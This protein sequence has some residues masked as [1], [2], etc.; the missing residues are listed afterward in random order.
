[1]SNLC[2]RD[3]KR[4]HLNLES[5][6]NF[7]L[8]NNLKCTFRDSFSLVACLFTYRH[9]YLCFDYQT[10]ST[11]PSNERILSSCR[12]LLILYLS[13]CHN[14]RGMFKIKLLEAKFS[15]PCRTVEDH[16]TLIDSLGWWF[17]TCGPLVI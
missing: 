12:H 17:S 1:M 2:F 16:G 6:C 7:L 5:L 15:S 11:L 10:K 3:A 8:T 4:L 13:D 14:K 9:P